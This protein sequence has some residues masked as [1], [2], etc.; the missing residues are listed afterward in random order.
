MYILRN[1]SLV[2]REIYYNISKRRDIFI[3]KFDFI[4]HIL[5]ISKLY[6]SFD[7][8]IIYYSS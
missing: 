3:I 7:L 2:F 8:F 4:E 1:I 6:A 5:L